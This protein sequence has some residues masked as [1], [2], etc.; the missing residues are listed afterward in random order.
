M[1]RY[2]HLE[3]IS[4]LWRRSHLKSFQIITR[5]KIKTA[6]ARFIGVEL[7]IVDGGDKI[8]MRQSEYIN[9][10]GN[11]KVQKDMTFDQLRTL[12]AQ[13]SYEASCAVP[14]VLIFVAVLSQITEKDFKADK[15]LAWKRLKKQQSGM[16]TEAS[17]N[18]LNVLHVLPG[19]SDVIFCIHTI[20]AIND[21][22]ALQREFWPCFGTNFMDR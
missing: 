5:W 18:V 4:L 10:N 13:L 7:T 12:H 2:A 19:N 16:Y 8:I 1:I 20:F 17:F 11:I 22:K 14:H 6:P 21:Y 9:K 15:A 3:R